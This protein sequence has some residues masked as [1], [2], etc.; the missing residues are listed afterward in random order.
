MVVSVAV[1]GEGEICRSSSFVFM[2]V[3]KQF[4]QLKIFHVDKVK[5][6]VQTI[7]KPLLYFLSTEK[8]IMLRY[9]ALSACLA[10]PRDKTTTILLVTT[11][12]DGGKLKGKK[13]VGVIAAVVVGGWI[14]GVVFCRRWRI[15]PLVRY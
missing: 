12:G 2:I 8:G 4:Y 5:I 1:V 6:T 3:V 7:K 15:V 11:E 13:E 14:S 10:A 9:M